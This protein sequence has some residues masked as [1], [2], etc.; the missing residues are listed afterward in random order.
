MRVRVGGEVANSVEEKV[1]L[2]S[3][4]CRRRDERVRSAGPNGRSIV[5]RVRRWAIC[6]CRPFCLFLFFL[7]I[8]VHPSGKFLLSLLHK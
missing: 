3:T 4:G 2:R 6:I 5:S 1:L 7:S 8:R